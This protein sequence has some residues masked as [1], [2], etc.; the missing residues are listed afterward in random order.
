MD[1]ELDLRTL[2]RTALLYWRTLVVAVLI[3]AVAAVALVFVTPRPVRA[4]ADVLISPNSEQLTLDPR[5]TSRDA[6]LLTTSS[7]QRQALISL[8]SSAGI[9]AR[10]AERL[11]AEGQLQAY[12]PGSLLDRISVVA[13]GDLVRIIVSDPD[14][15]RALRLATLWGEAYEGLVSELYSRNNG[16]S[17]QLD[18]QIASARQRYDD[19][20]KALEQFLAISDR[21]AVEQQILRVS[22][23]LD[24]S[25]GASTLLYTQ[26]LTRV[27]ELDLIIADAGILR[28]QSA[29]G[30]SSDLSSSLSVLALRARVAGGVELPVQLRFDD[31][32]SLT[33][34][35]GATVRELDSLIDALIEE[36]SRLLER[37]LQLAQDIASGDESSAGLTPELR[38]TYE[39]TLA[40]LSA[41]REQLNG[42]EIALTQQRDI[43]LSS[44]ELLRQKSDE[45]QIA[46]NVAQVDVRVVSVGS[47]PPTSLLFTLLINLSLGLIAGMVLGVIAALV[48]ALRRP[49]R[50]A[51]LQPGDFSADRP[52]PTH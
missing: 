13:Q 49:R 31:P 36:Q 11:I 18:V 38:A 39:R 22:G 17:N 44:L 1:S 50:A 10:V 48:R 41:Q 34:T 14:S 19:S 27:Q 42:T 20:Q 21:V 32:S 43:A 16:S 52:A 35:E 3:A 4:S 25:R 15:Q 28:E 29:N 33:S 30:S 51:S 6:T 12:I 7:F 46:K 8:A 37:S 26:Y 9:E 23:I 45:E 47:V 40:E 5:Y 24:G 2:L